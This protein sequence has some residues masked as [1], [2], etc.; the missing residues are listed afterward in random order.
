MKYTAEGKF[1]NEKQAK[2]DLATCAYAGKWKAAKAYVCRHQDHVLP[3]SYWDA[4]RLHFLE[5]GGEWL[6]Q[7]TPR[8]AAEPIP[9]SQIPVLAPSFEYREPQKV[10][11]G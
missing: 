9:W 6:D 7:V 11:E 5:L 2:A 4:V 1:R 8:I 10:R 3:Y